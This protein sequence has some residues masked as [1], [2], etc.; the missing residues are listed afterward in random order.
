[1]YIDDITISCKLN[2]NNLKKIIIRHNLHCL[3]LYLIQSSLYI[4]L[5]KVSIPKNQNQIFG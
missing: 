3:V 2:P 5:V 4:K 1:M